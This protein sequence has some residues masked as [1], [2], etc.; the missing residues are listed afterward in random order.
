MTTKTQTPT[1]TQNDAVIVAAKVLPFLPRASSP[2]RERDF[3][4]GYGRSSGYA[5]EK[6][7]TSDWG[8]PRFRCG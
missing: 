3:G 8:T 5:L 4:I 6:R 2:R 7:Y 1:D